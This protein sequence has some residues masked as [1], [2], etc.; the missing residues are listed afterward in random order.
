MASQ[1]ATPSDHADST[2]VDMDNLSG[3]Q[4]HV[5]DSG[6]VAHHDTPPLRRNPSATMDVSFAAASST[7]PRFNGM[8]SSLFETRFHEEAG[9]Y[10]MYA[11]PEYNAD[12]FGRATV[13][14]LHGVTDPAAI[15]PLARH[16]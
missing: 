16:T 3:D 2:P 9:S 13:D 7:D 5:L 14:N 15:I 11:P 4:D 12:A 6:I 1:Q 8:I 10:T